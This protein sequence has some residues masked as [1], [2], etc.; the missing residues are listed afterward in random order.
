MS[1]SKR[2]YQVLSGTR[3][4]YIVCSHYRSPLPRT[5]R[6]RETRNGA[7]ATARLTIGRATARPTKTDQGRPNTAAVPERW[8]DRRC[9]RPSD[10]E[11]TIDK[12]SYNVSTSRSCCLDFS[13]NPAKETRF[14]KHPLSVVQTGATYYPA[15]TG[16]PV[17]CSLHAWYCFYSVL[18]CQ[19]QAGSSTKKN[20]FSPPQIPLAISSQRGNIWCHGD[21]HDQ[22]K[23]VTWPKQNVPA[24]GCL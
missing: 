10:C 7:R 1:S 19:V 20:K 17:I 12:H 18:A 4:I 24:S 11:R 15:T 5:T 8:R 3:H 23:R 13:N 14:N 2:K 22:W 16:V 21:P 9:A 6:L